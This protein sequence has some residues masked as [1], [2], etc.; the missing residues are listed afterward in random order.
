M[1]NLNVKIIKLPSI[2]KIVFLIIL[3]FILITGRGF[4]QGIRF[5]FFANPQISWLK[6]DIKEVTNEGSRSGINIGISMNSYFTN[7][8]A[9]STG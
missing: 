8:Y 9:F 2:A 1:K 6:P 5:G 7:N 3:S 4:S